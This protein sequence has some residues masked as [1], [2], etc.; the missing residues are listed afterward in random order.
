MTARYPTAATN[1]ATADHKNTAADLGLRLTSTSSCPRKLVNKPHLEE[2]CWC[3]SRLNDH[4]RRYHDSHDEPVVIWEPYDASRDEL[5]HLMAHA[6]DEDL[7][8]TVSGESPWN[9]GR[10]FAILFRRNTPDE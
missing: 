10:T 2:K 7:Q 8:V 6:Y 5:L 9:P 4:G 1:N 3:T